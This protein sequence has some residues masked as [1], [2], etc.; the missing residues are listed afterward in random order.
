MNTIILVVEKIISLAMKY[1]NLTGRK[2][3]ITGE[4]GEIL[5]CNCKERKLKELKL[6]LAANQ[7]TP[8]Y[9]AVDKNGKKYQIK[10]RRAINWDRRY[11]GRVK[12]SMHKFDYAIF[13]IL[14]NEYELKELYKISYK[15]LTRILERYPRR[16]PHI[17]T[18]VKNSERVL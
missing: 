15:K 4:V 2:L 17:A 13:A 11:L 14:N 1:E 10:T 6:K 7:Q 12:F 5:V 18:L 9:D 16:N 3:E 8:G